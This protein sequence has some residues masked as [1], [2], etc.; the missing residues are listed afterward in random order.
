MLGNANLTIVIGAKTI[1]NTTI[2]I[3][4]VDAIIIQ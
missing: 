4:D 3:F 1:N 2:S